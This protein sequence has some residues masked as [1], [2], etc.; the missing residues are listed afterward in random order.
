MGVLRGLRLGI[1]VPFFYMPD[2]CLPLL[3][4]TVT[5]F[6]THFMLVGDQENEEKIE[7][8][9][10]ERYQSYHCCAVMQG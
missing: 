10:T 2:A 5:N 6:N 8:A 9:I 7:E 4:S 1:D 3:K